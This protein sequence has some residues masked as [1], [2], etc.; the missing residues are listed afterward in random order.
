M[1]TKLQQP[2]SMRKRGFT[3]LEIAISLALLAIILG[4][5]IGSVSLIFAEQRIME[6]VNEFQR[7]AAEASRLASATRRPHSIMI[8]VDS[9]VL[10][11][12]NLRDSDV[13]AWEQEMRDRKQ[14]ISELQSDN[15]SSSQPKHRIVEKYQLAKDV[16]I[17]W[18]RWVDKHYSDITPEQNAEWRFSPSGIC[19]PASIRIENNDG[20]VE[21][22]FNPLTAKVEDERMSINE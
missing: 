5:S 3:L 16:N 11:E 14:G 21:L 10:R 18:R 17:G 9:F 12:S 8:S 19:E 1:I 13:K 2:Q 7:M 6:P 20:W 22:D 4:V 15:T